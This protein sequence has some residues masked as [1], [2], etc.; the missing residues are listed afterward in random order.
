MELISIL[1]ACY[2]T[3]YLCC[4]IVFSIDFFL[5]F[6]LGAGAGAGRSGCGGISAIG[7]FH[8]GDVNDV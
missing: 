2:V 1:S 5:S 7:T 4:F 8:V 6:V 3:P